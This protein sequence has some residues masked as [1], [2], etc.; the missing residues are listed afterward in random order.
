MH[1][2]INSMIAQL[3]VNAIWISEWHIL[4]YHSFTLDDITHLLH[5]FWDTHISYDIIPQC[6]WKILETKNMKNLHVH[7]VWSQTGSGAI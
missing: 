3:I 5:K 2:G 4:V 6:W 1:K 7:M